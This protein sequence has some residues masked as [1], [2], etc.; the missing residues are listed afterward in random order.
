MSPNNP[1]K[2]DLLRWA[3]GDEEDAEYFEKRGDHELAAGKRALATKQ[4]E[5]AANWSRLRYLIR[6]VIS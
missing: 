5:E 6:T 2:A 4:R 1:T 3:A